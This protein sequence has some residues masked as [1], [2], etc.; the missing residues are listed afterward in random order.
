MGVREAE[1]RAATGGQAEGREAVPQGQGARLAARAR[2]ADAGTAAGAAA[3]HLELGPPSGLWHSQERGGAS[4]RCGA[5]S[6]SGRVC[7]GRRMSSCGDPQPPG[8][9]LLLGA[10]RLL[11]RSSKLGLL[12]PPAALPSSSSHPPAPRPP[13]ARRPPHAT[14]DRRRQLLGAPQLPPPSRSGAP[15]RHGRRPHRPGRAAAPA[16]L[17][18]GQVP[19]LGAAHRRRRRGAARRPP[20]P[21]PRVPGCALAG[22]W[23]RADGARTRAT[24]C[25]MQVQCAAA[26]VASRCRRPLARPAATLNRLAAAIRGLEQQQAE[27]EQRAADVRERESLAASLLR[28][29]PAAWLPARLLHVTLSRPSLF[30]HALASTRAQ[31]TNTPRR[32]GA[33]AGRGRGPASRAGG[34][35]GGAG[36]AAGAGGRGA[37]GAGCRGD[38]LR[39]AGG[40]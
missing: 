27:L 23:C 24:P 19:G 39:T 15:Q 17:V 18:P 33:G 8:G 26:A 40:G 28:R 20:R 36:A 30:P 21:P 35:A 7:W 22:G 6:G 14:L 16:G 5:L 37:G 2:P 38:C 3:A 32:A 25:G 12:G 9:R 13:C 34:G 4:C 10:A 11:R 1:L 29:K 31:P